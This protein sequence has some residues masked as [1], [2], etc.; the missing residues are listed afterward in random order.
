VSCPGRSLAWGKTRYPL[1]RRLGGPQGQSGQAREISSP[2]GFDSRTV[3][4][5]ASRYT[6]WGTRLT[7]I[8]KTY[9]NSQYIYVMKI[10]LSITSVN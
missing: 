7:D 1:S 8:C 2:P 9:L 10:I 6:D 3:Q 5:V 4:P